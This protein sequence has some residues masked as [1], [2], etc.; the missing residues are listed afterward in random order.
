MASM[1][2]LIGRLCLVSLARG[3]ASS[4][5]PG[6]LPVPAIQPD[7]QGQIWDHFH[8]SNIV[9]VARLHKGTH[10]EVA[11]CQRV[12]MAQWSRGCCCTAGAARSHCRRRLK[13]ERSLSS[14]HH[15]QD[16][17]VGRASTDDMQQGCQASKQ[18]EASVPPSQVAENEAG[19]AIVVVVVVVVV[20]CTSVI[21]V[22][23]VVVIG[24]SSI[25]VIVVVVVYTPSSSVVVVVVV[26]C[27]PQSLLAQLGGR[28]A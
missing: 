12:R 18:P 22:V 26:I 28:A 25:V 21:V 7:S 14:R 27:T 15:R 11:Q 17:T 8:L 1:F 2:V 23:I 4:G 19:L 9:T 10:A 16:T 6:A 3:T 20:G 24:T 5:F 13:A